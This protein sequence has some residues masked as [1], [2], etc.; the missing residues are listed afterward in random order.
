MSTV[1]EFMPYI[2]L[3]L[4]IVAG[5]AAVVLLDGGEDDS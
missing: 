1:R 5:I 4:T 3:A 2:F